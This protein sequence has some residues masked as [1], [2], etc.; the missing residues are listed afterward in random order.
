MAEA[1]ERCFLPDN[2]TLTENTR[3]LQLARTRYISDA[4]TL[5][6]DCM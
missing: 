1:P 2:M 3:H 5:T 6:S 4:F